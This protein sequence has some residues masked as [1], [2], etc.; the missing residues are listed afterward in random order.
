M[1]L[2]QFSLEQLKRS[3][4]FTAIAAAAY[5]SGEKLYDR[6]YGEVQDYSRKKGVILTEILLPEHAP[7]RLKD[8]ETLWYEVESLE[9][10]KDSQLAY[11]FEFALQNELTVEE[12]IALAKRFV[13]ENLVSH[14]MVC[15]I[16]IH[17]P[18]RKEGE[19]PNP[20]IHVMGAMRPILENGQ[21]G[22]KRL[23]VPLF[24]EN[25]Q[26]ILNRKGKQKYADPFTTDWNK[27]ETLERW[28]ES[29]ANMVNE[30]FIEKGLPCRI[31]HRSYERQGLDIVP[32]VH[33]GSAVRRMEARGITTYKGTWNRWVRATNVSIKNLLAKLVELADW[34]KE[35]REQI[36]QIENPSI[37]TMVMEYYGHRDEVANGFS[38]GV[39]KAH[40]SNMKLA[41]QM[42][43]YIERNK[44]VDA[45]AIEALIEAKRKELSDS[46]S[47]VQKKR[48]D[49]KRLENNLKMIADYRVTKPV[50]DEAQKIF[51]K[52][53]K[54]EFQDA[55]KSELN[56][57]YKA[58]RVL[59]EQGIEEISFDTAEKYWTE[60]IASLK[61]EIKEESEKVK[62]SPINDEVELLEK[63]KDAVDFA[64]KKNGGGDGDSDGGSEGAA[65]GGAVS[66]PV[67]EDKKQTQV[68]AAQEQARQ[69]EQI[70]SQRQAHEVQS[71]D[72]ERRV[73]MKKNLAEKKVIV[74]KYKEE[75][76]QQGT[77]QKN[78]NRDQNRS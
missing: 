71:H 33:E 5:R 20:H 52:A 73:S 27:P 54:K 24:D 58:R 49:L 40:T 78:K 66:V 22:A 69:T 74:E 76:Y 34:F 63:I 55:Y 28:R 35:A 18:P 26:P 16:A 43:A 44:L 59:D 75:H 4:G 29:W 12:N 38:R 53:R 48:E 67:K 17:N 70:N 77:I 46:N 2:F 68:K 56:K 45:D 13:M 42:I 60:K 50:Y 9:K 47:S 30:K 72:T 23:H 37:T 51:F 62:S 6:Y 25:G 61:E 64:I 41:A 19:E 57:F 15:D 36:K 1:A 14:G 39:Q 3:D 31:D 65:G 11:M 7:E 10:R 32:Q 8:R 21:W